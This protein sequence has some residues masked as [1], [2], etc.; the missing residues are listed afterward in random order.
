MLKGRH[1][2]DY[3]WTN[4]GFSEAKIALTDKLTTRFE[5]KIDIEICVGYFWIFGGSYK[6]SW[7]RKRLDHKGNLRKLN[8]SSVSF[9]TSTSLKAK[10]R[11]RIPAPTKVIK[12]FANI[13]P[14]L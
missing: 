10:G 6:L 1:E 13:F 3:D 8:I 12:M 5:K 4:V 14:V 7:R 2:S 9:S 11:P